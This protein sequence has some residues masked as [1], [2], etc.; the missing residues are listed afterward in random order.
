MENWKPPKFVDHI[1]QHFKRAKIYRWSRYSVEWGEWS[2]K[3]NLVI[4]K[5][6]E[7]KEDPEEL[8]LKYVFLYWIT[9][10]QE[11]EYWHKSKIL[12]VG[13]RVGLA[14]DAEGLS[15]MIKSGAYPKFDPRLQ[16]P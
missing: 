6:I 12:H 3:M 7:S 14:K 13:K 10:S 5:R 16:T 9:K 15:K 1:D 11:L 2:R 8:G 4:R